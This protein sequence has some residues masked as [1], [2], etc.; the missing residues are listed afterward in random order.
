MTD[1]SDTRAET[2]RMLK[3]AA[4][5]DDTADAWLT[6][7]LYDRLRSRAAG[8]LGPR[9]AAGPM[10]P[11]ELVHEAWMRLID[12]RDVDPSERTYFMYV[13][14]LAMKRVLADAR[15][16]EIAGKRDGRRATNEHALDSVAGREGGGTWIARAD[17]DAALATIEKYAPERAQVARLLLVEGLDQGEAA[18]RLGRSRQWVNEEFR[19]V[20]ETIARLF[21]LEDRHGS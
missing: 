6:A 1:P 19:L 4:F 13:A 12:Q 17:L 11:T 2:T 21:Q 9:V 3:R 16:A 5:G 10:Q 14:G 7:T 15:R 20:R 8:I 18:A